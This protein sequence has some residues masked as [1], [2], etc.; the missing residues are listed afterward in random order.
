MLVIKIFF[1]QVRYSIFLCECNIFQ[2]DSL[3]NIISRP[4]VIDV[5]IIKKIFLQ[6]VLSVFLISWLQLY[7]QFPQLFVV[8][9][10]EESWCFFA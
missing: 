5:A 4:F 6:S 2:D 7:L 3:P 1:M 10:H 8:F 9:E